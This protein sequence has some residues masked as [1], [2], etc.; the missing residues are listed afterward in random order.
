MQLKH[1][2]CGNG[3]VQQ[4]GFFALVI[5]VVGCVQVDSSDDVLKNFSSDVNQIVPAN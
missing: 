5:S 3:L 1:N 2:D 4:N